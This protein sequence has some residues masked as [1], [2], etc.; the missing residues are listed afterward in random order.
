M[1]E[2]VSA[3][4]IALATGKAKRVITRRAV[5]EG[6]PHEAASGRGGVARRYI[7]SSLPADIKSALRV[8]AG[9]QP[10]PAGS[11]LIR[12][13]AAGSGSGL[14]RK[15]TAPYGCG[16]VSGYRAALVRKYTEALA[17]A[18]KGGKGRARELFIKAYNSGASLP[19]IYQV[20]GNTSWQTIERWKVQLRAYGPDSLSDLRGKHRQGLSSVTASQAEVLLKVALHPNRHPISEAIRLAKHAMH[21]RGINDGLSDST[22]RRWLKQWQSLHYDEWTWYRDGVKGWNDKVA[23]YIERDYDLIQVGDVLVADGHKL[24]FEIKNPYNGKPQRMALILWFDMKSAMPCGWDIMPTEN[25]AVIATALRRAVIRL[26]KYPRVLYLDNGKAFGAKFFGGKDLSQQGFEGLFGR[27]GVEGVIYAWPYHAQSKTVERFFRD[28]AELERMLPSYSG[29]SIS[30]K[31]ARMNRGEKLH[32]QIYQKVTGGQP[33]SLE[34]AHLAIAWWFDLYAD[35]EHKSGHLKGK[36]SGE[37]FE[38]GKGPGVNVQGLNH[39]ML[40][41]EVRTIHRKGVRLCGRY[42]YHPALYGRRHPVT[43][44]YDLQDGTY[45]LVYDKQGNFICRAEPPRAVHPAAEYLGTDEDREEL[46]NQIALRRSQEKQTTRAAREFLRDQILPDHRRRL[47]DAGLAPGS[48]PDPG[49]HSEAVPSQ[50]ARHAAGNVRELPSDYECEAEKMLMMETEATE[51]ELASE[52]ESLEECPDRERY[53]GLIEVELR[54]DDLRNGDRTFLRMFE[55][56]DE[57]L[58]NREYYE[59]RKLSLSIM[60][61]AEGCGNEKGEIDAEAAG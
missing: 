46:R 21:Q 7:V 42:Y 40:A 32:R 9:P 51:A 48:S 50:G 57:Y 44:R 15:Q 8:G 43:V 45:I 61:G 36:T 58:D 6:W 11:A 3:S 23:Y 47:A 1:A 13:Q 14:I 10:E 17:R 49:P 31:P 25:T 26:G 60:F 2:S 55:A 24:N 5:R 37:V 29:T 41:T 30:E 52:L 38:A 33:L 20:V 22:Y 39:L 19:E 4:E 27:L 16:A 54:G 34:E 35:R 59:D 12:Q 53:L 18:P 28:F 56:S